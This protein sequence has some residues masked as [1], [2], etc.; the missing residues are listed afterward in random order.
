MSSAAVLFQHHHLSVFRYLR[1]M[2]G[3]TEQAEDLTQEVFLRAVRAL[4]SDPELRE[5]AWLFRTARNLLLNQRRDDARKPFPGDLREAPPQP[6][7]GAGAMELDQA[8]AG[9][10]GAD[11]EVFLMRELGGLGYEEISGICGLTPAAV[12]SRIYRA[13]IALRAALSEDIRRQPRRPSTEARS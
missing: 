11:R 6:P 3:S 5:R 9:I 10:D 1:R 12:R 4:P 8:L 13:R 7:A 2:T